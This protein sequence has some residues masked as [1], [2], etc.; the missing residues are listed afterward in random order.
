MNLRRL[1]TRPRDAGTGRQ[2]ARALPAAMLLAV[3]LPAGPVGAD[4]Y[5]CAEPRAPELERPS[6]DS[7]ATRGGLWFGTR[8]PAPAAC[9]WVSEEGERIDARVEALPARSD[10]GQ[11]SSW[12][13]VTSE[14]A[15][16]GW[17]RWALE[18]ERPI[19]ACDR[20]GCAGGW[21]PATGLPIVEVAPVERPPSLERAYLERWTC[22]GVDEDVLRV[23]L[24]ALPDGFW[25]QGGVLRVRYGDGGWALTGPGGEAVD[26]PLAPLPAPTRDDRELLIELVDGR[27]QLVARFEL[28]LDSEFWQTVARGPQHGRA[29]G[30]SRESV[31]SS[32][33]R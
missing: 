20:H 19:S 16:D 9:A 24:T 4:K 15:L 23:Q 17:W 7:Y 1:S 6:P 33:P 21:L 28:A 31:S 25:A 5:P 8:E 3:L 18:C 27:A 13:W 29:R 2:A 26:G 12:V 32:S 11:I 10:T 30:C 14:A 22:V